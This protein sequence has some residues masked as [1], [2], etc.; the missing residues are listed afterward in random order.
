VLLHRARAA[1]LKKLTEYEL[2]E[3]LE[4]RESPKMEKLR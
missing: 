4:W 1:F 2:R 3:A